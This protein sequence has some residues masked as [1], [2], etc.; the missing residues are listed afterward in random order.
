MVAATTQVFVYGSLLEPQALQ[1]TLPTVSLDA[2]RTTRLHGFV[3]V[4]NVAFPNDGSQADKAYFDAHGKR[5]PYV[6]FANL[7]VEPAGT[8]NGLVVELTDR[9]L[10]DLCERERRYRLL[11]VSTAIDG[12]TQTATP[13]WAFVGLE[14]FTSPD[15]VSRGVVPQEYLDTIVAGAREWDASEAGFF[16]EFTRSTVFAPGDSVVALERV[17]RDE[18]V[19]RE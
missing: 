8:V 16:D 7:R 13:V 9:E 14:G 12:A 17:D 1:S 2:P 19:G 5:P 10:A 4:F 11:D 15:H 6:L 18:P 3:R